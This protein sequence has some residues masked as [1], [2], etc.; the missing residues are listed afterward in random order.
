MYV[1]TNPCLVSREAF[2]WADAIPRLRRTT[3]ASTT[4]PLAS[5]RAALHSIIP[6]PVSSR[7]CFTNAAVISAIRFRRLFVC[8]AGRGMP[9]PYNCRHGPGSLVSALRCRGRLGARFV[10][11]GRGALAGSLSRFIRH[12]HALRHDLLGI[13]GVHIFRVRQ[14]A[15]FSRGLIADNLVGRE[16]MLGSERSEEH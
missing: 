4:S 5:T 10:C 14:H 16:V 15:F 8:C 13:L 2:L 7:N 9:R 6:A 1:P 3:S 11:L 12:A